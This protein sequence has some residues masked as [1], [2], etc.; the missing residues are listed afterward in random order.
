MSLSVCPADTVQASVE[1]VWELLMH[2]VDYDHF[3]DMTVERVEP[4][5][6]AR[7]GQKFVWSS[8]ALCR[9]WRIDGEIQEVDA[10][11]HHILFRLTLPLGLISSNR[12]MCARI[13]EHSCT[14]RYG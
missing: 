7:L 1:K 3:W 10:Q 6:P 8:R 4:E 5:G 12:I 14:L 2:P 11:R 9:R 13:D